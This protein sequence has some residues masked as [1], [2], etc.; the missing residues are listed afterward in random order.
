V[1]PDDRVLVGVVNRKR[2][3]AHLR[4]DRWYRIPQSRMKR[5][6]HAEYLGFFLSGRAFKE[7]SGAVHYYARY[8]GVELA[9]RRDLLPGEPDHP[10]AGD[11]YYKV[12]I[13][14]LKEKTPPITNPNRR[15]V[16]F[17]YTTWDR[18]VHAQ[19]ISDLYSQADY[20]VD[21]VYHALR[22]R[23]IQPERFWEA[24]RRETGFGAQVR[25]LCERGTVTVSAE[26]NT[27]SIYLD[28]AH[29]Y[30]TILAAIYAQIA[31]QGGPVL[32]N[33]PLDC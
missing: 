30:D 25:I 12:Q 5:G 15:V 33:I 3:F 13:D 18:F 1:Y 11:I 29:D 24:E 31:R 6:I 16:S 32:V 23:G 22:Q 17:V 26:K 8:A 2:D 20:Y 4:D 21:R 7:R 9:Y 19:T 14:E 28:D 10:R 27:G